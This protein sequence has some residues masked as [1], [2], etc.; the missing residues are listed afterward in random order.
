M[1]VVPPI[2]R[3]SRQLP[4]PSPRANSTTLA[5]P[6]D[7]RILTGDSSCVVPRVEASASG[8]S[9][10]VSPGHGPAPTRL[11]VRGRA[12]H[13]RLV[14]QAAAGRRQ[15]AGLPP[16][17]A[18]RC[19]HL[20]ATHFSLL[21]VRFLAHE[22]ESVRAHTWLS[23]RAEP[24]SGRVPDGAGR[25]SLAACCHLQ[26]LVMRRSSACRAS[27]CTCRRRRTWRG[28]VDRRPP[29]DIDSVCGAHHVDLVS[30]TGG[31]LPSGGRR[32]RWRRT[33]R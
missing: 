18:R 19:P 17:T 13:R 6:T 7:S 1:G 31:P 3:V 30:R 14:S 10:A 28:G 24:A 16:C 20:P 26:R 27:S 22:E 29:A 12:R 2:R 8:P 25:L 11:S 23:I 33:E 4:C 9:S 32:Q 21:P 5:S 15:P